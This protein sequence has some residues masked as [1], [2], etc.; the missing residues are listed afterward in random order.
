MISDIISKI[1]S[2]K[3]QILDREKSYFVTYINPYNYSLLINKRTVL[4]G[5]DFITLDGILLTVIF[6]IFK[7]R[8]VG[9]LSPDFSSYFLDLFNSSIEN[10]DKLY[11][12]GTEWEK[13]EI[14][15]ENFKKQFEG[16]NIAGYHS[17]FFNK[18]E[19]HDLIKEIISCDV[20]IVIVGMGVRRQEEFLCSLKKN[21]WKGRGY[22]CGGF[23]H[24]SSYKTIYY[25]KW[26]SKVHLRWVYRM[27]MEPKLIRRYL[28]DY[29]IAMF[30][31]IRDII[32][33]KLN[34]KKVI[35]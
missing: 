2:S 33:Y 29:P 7:I 30:Y 16:I 11:L 6:N 10:N 17:G 5:I 35:L 12:V 18:E 8:K 24:Q 25:P 34:S 20:D 13:L 4:D 14:A 19:E 26:V 23:L 28:W 15:I 21:G 1:P 3:E 32:S 31:I 9:R 22:A 27:C